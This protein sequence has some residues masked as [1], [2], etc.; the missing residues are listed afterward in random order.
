MDGTNEFETRTIIDLHIGVDRYGIDRAV[1]DAQIRTDASA[2]FD[3]AVGCR[4]ERCRSLAYRQIH[5]HAKA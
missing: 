5:T 3:Q 1:E 2:N 4:R